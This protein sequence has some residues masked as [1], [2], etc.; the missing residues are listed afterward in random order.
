M[1]AGNS[2]ISGGFPSPP[3][4]V[5]PGYCDENPFIFL[6]HSFVKRAQDFAEN[7][8]VQNCHILKPFSHYICQGGWKA[9][10]AR[11]DVFQFLQTLSIIPKGIYI[12]LGENDL[13][14]YQHRQPH[15]VVE[16]LMQLGMSFLKVGTKVVIFHH[17]MARNYKWHPH[18]PSN[19]AIVHANNLL[20]QE[21]QRSKGMVFWEGVFFQADPSDFVTYD[22]VHLHYNALKWYCRE[23]VMIRR[24]YLQFCEPEQH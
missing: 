5:Q 9:D 12:H 11:V 17:L 13:F 21:V 18:L 4:E 20:K 1:A 8:I 6:G 22:R 2:R 3:P 7:N 24:H 19:D 10:Q 14:G 23:L 16:D 15:E